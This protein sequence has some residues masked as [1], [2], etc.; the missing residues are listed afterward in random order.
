MMN[1]QSRNQYLSEL[2]TEYLK[3]K[4]KKKKSELLEEAL[5]RTK[6]CRKHLIVKLKAIY[7]MK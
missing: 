3:T 5:K 2:R 1:M 6:L 7:H 4:S